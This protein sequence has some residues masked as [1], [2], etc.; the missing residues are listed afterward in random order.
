MEAIACDGKSIRAKVISGTKIS[1]R[2]GISL[3]DTDLPV[4]ALT[5]KDRKDLDAVL[6]PMSTG[7]RCPS[8]SG[9]TIW[10][11]CARSRAGAPRIM[12]K[13][14]KPQAVTGSTRSSSFPTR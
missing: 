4:G 3:P 10:P 9:R 13:I 1:D 8:F 7:S 14:E 2:K 11:K 12:S 6:P 5:D